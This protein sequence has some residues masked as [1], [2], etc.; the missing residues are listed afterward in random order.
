[1]LIA[2]THR[3]YAIAEK[4]AMG[5]GRADGAAMLEAAGASAARLVAAD[6]QRLADETGSVISAALFGALAGAAPCR[7]RAR[8]SRP[9]CARGG[10]G[11]AAS[12][13]AFARGFDAAHASEAA[14]RQTTA[15]E[16]AEAI[17]AEGARRCAEW[18]D[19]AYAEKYRARLEESAR[20]TRNAATAAI[21][22]CARRR[23]IWRCG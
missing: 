2:S 7:S 17:V 5:D 20:S 6:M 15:A 18:Q 23:G 16:D 3:I 14:A 19:A 12:L 10:V 8:S 22:C 4:I 13:A 11:V 21:A 1:M 9:R